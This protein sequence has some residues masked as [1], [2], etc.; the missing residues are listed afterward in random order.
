MRL[1]QFI[2]KSLFLMTSRQ[3]IRSLKK[4]GLNP[5]I[6]KGE[7]KKVVLE[8]LIIQTRQNHQIV[9]VQITRGV[10]NRNHAFRKPLVQRYL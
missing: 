10:A 1:C 8:E 6:K 5:C 9:Y 4:K 2:I 7:N 3:V